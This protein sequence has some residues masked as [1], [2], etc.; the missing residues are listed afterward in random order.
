MVGAPHPFRFGVQV[1]AAADAAAW[2]DLARRAEALGY[3]VLAMP[4]HVG[5]QFAYAPALAAAACTTTRLRIGTLVLATDFRQPATVAGEATTLDLLS[6]GRYELGLGVGGSLLDDYTLLGLPFAP[7]GIRVGRFAESLAAI[8]GLFG[9]EPVTLA[10]RHVRLGGLV[11]FPRPVQRPHPPILIG[12]GGARMLAL[13]ARE[14]DIVSV[15]V[16]MSPAGEF[17]LRDVRATALDAKVALLRASAGDRFA[18]LE[19]HL[20]VQQLA[21]GDAAPQVGA[22][23]AGR[24]HL[25]PEEVAETPYA[26]I[27]TVDSIVAQLVARRRRFGFSYYTVRDRDMAAFAPVVAALAGH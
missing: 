7:P 6:G 25:T 9:A 27:G 16:G 17:D 4:D 13:A 12:A 22:A 8:K 15:L 21:I 11:G 24:W 10:G 1:A 20:L 18:R 26:L 14:A 3:D 2:A 23:L 5:I 19:L